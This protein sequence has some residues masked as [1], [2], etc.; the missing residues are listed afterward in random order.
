MYLGII[1]ISTEFRPD[2]CTY[3]VPLGKSNSQY[4]PWF[5]HQG[6]K[7]ENTKSDITPELM[8]GSSQ[9]FYHRDI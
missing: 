3:Y 8:A 7:T 4:D 6:A 1:Y 2:L 5:G 9:N